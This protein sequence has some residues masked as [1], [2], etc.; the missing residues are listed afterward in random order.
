MAAKKAPEKKEEMTQESR[1]CFVVTPIGGDSSTTRRAAD[2]L[3][4][5]VIEPVCKDLGLEVV[6]AHRIDTPGSITTQVIEHVLNDDLVIANLS[7]LNPNV[8]YELG[9][10]HA[11]RKPVIS[12][13]VEGTSLP[14]D[15]SDERTIF[16]KNDMAGVMELKMRLE[17]MANEALS[18]EEPDNPVY[19]AMTHK[20]IKDVVSSDAEGGK[21]SKYM[22]DK[23]DKLESIIS[24]LST[25]IGS[26]VNT[27]SLT[28][29]N[30]RRTATI[31]DFKNMHISFSVGKH[32][33][34]VP[35]FIS[36]LSSRLL[37]MFNVTS[38][39]DMGEGWSF[40]V[41]N[42][43]GANAVIEYLNSL[44]EVENVRYYVGV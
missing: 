36:N 20:I 23:L 44:A 21:V 18:D 28:T 2:G 11:A 17:I 31:G 10:R 4:D 30:S 14:F 32:V 9:L 16:F 7:E 13:A 43:S 26:A 29:Q 38:M 37:S 39:H 15:I 6:V 19:R 1:K 8:M 27:G 24:S 3:I 12:L 41:K 5:S 22:L 33:T 34:D 35:E 25:S 42:S 40:K